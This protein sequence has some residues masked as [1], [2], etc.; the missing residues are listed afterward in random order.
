MLLTLLTISVLHA[1]P[2]YSVIVARRLGVDAK[3]AAELATECATALEAQGASPLG[4]LV[5][6]DE[7]ASRLAAAGFPDA[8]VCNGA[9]ACVASLARVSGLTRMVSLQLVKIGADLAIDASVVE[10]DSGQSVAAVTRTVKLKAAPAGL[11]ELAAQLLARVPA[12]KPQAPPQPTPVAEHLP[13]DAP[14][15]TTLTPDPGPPPQPP[16]VSAA[17][18]LPV[19]RKVAIGLAA[20]AVIALGVGIG[21]GVSALSQSKTLSALDP[22]YADKAA[23]TQRTA[24]I[25]DASYGTAGALAIGAGLAWFL[26]P[27]AQ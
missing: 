12:L 23:A 1:G 10:G 22:L 7:A 2:E 5:P 17:P 9:S 20:G 11:R 3:K 16:L 21:L 24:N 18:T 13:D 8:A 19:G 26:S 27:P 6:V 4:T 25:A 15:N 14:K